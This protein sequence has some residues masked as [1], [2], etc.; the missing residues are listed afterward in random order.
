LETTDRR[1]DL[2]CNYGGLFGTRKRPECFPTNR[3]A[4]LCGA[5]IA[6][7]DDDGTCG[8]GTAAVPRTAGLLASLPGA[9]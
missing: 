5:Q 4:L 3:A 9:G 8:T 7:F 2:D 1:L 6:D